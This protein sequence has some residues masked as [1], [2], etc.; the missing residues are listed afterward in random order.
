MKQLESD[1]DG[2]RLYEPP[3]IVTINLRPEEAVLGNCKISATSG[4]KT[5]SC[6][7]ITCQ[8]IGS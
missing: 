4:S 7:V 1:Q 2:K 6:S 8:S 5:T 3:K